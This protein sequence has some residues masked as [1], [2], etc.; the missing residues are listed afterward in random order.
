[1]KQKVTIGLIPR[2]R[3]S[4]ASE[5]IQTIYEHTTIPFDLVIVDCNIPEKYLAQIN[6]V[7]LGRRNFQ[8]IHSDHYLLP[9]QSRNLVLSLL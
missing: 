8:I 1:M 3:F 5:A 6:H 2:E 4:L 7:L 9:G